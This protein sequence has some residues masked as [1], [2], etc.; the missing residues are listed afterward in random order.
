MPLSCPSSPSGSL[1]IQ[2][3]LHPQPRPQGRLVFP[4]HKA[5]S[6]CGDRI[7]DHFNHQNLVTVTTYFTH[8]AEVL[9][10]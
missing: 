10:L 9:V 5:L 2:R 4:L 6:S 8:Q 3:P 1:R 7:Y